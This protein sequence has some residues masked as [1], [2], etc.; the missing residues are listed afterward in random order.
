MHGPR[1]ADIPTRSDSFRAWSAI[2]VRNGHTAAIAAL[3]LH[4]AATGRSAL[5]RA[6]ARLRSTDNRDPKLYRRRDS[7]LPARA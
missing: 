1:S 2:S 7:M 5:R 4:S 6:A 3:G